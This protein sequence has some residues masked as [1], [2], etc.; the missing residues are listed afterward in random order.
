MSQK[1]SSIDSWNENWSKLTKEEKRT[2]FLLF[3]GFATVVKL[4]SNGNERA[5][6]VLEKLIKLAVIKKTKIKQ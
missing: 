2:M 1:I 4:A 6:I 5:K 3:F